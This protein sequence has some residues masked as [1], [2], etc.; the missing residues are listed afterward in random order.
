MF[1]NFTKQKA[2][3]RRLRKRLM[4]MNRPIMIDV[5]QVP[6][7]DQCPWRL[8]GS[9]HCLSSQ[10]GWAWRL[11][12]ATN[13][14]SFYSSLVLISFLQFLSIFFERQ[15]VKPFVGSLIWLNATAPPIE[16]GLAKQYTKSSK[17]Q[18]LSKYQ[19]S[20]N[21]QACRWLYLVFGLVHLT[22]GMV[23]LVFG[24]CI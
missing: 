19:F 7:D 22:S 11:R 10:Q 12:Q 16:F 21:F 6:H 24:V 15:I 17:I 9:G 5:W 1:F 18:V 20:K 23:C 8:P 13:Q 4:K 14:V 3:W 2:W